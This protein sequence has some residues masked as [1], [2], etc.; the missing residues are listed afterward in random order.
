M[1]D[2]RTSYDAEDKRSS[3]QQICVLH[4]N[5]H[6]FTKNWTHTPSTSESYGRLSGWLA[7]EMRVEVEIFKIPFRL[8]YFRF[9]LRL[10]SVQCYYSIRSAF[11]SAF[12][13]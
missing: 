3:V 7:D 8:K 6:S 2:L 11:Q 12:L 4:V 5:Y 13:K 10:I 9:L 1:K